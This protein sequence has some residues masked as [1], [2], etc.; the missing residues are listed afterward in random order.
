MPTIII[1]VLLFMKNMIIMIP[2][3]CF[4]YK[5]M[6]LLFSFWCRGEG[7]GPRCWRYRL[8]WSLVLGYISNVKTPL[9]PFAPPPPPPAPLFPFI[10]LNMAIYGLQVVALVLDEGSWFLA[11]SL[12]FKN[13][14]GFQAK[15]FQPLPWMYRSP[16]PPPLQTF[17]TPSGSPTF[18]LYRPK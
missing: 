6:S 16:N 17:P 11:K 12:L 15:T 8:A 14:L 9:P 3:N 1:C 13:N 7:T 2:K 18:P 10:Y 5:R 4:Y